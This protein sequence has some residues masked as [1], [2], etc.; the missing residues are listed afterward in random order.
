V[1]QEIIGSMSLTPDPSDFINRDVV[2][3]RVYLDDVKVLADNLAKFGP[4]RI[5][6]SHLDSNVDSLVPDPLTLVGRNDISTIDVAIRFDDQF[7]L[8]GYAE[9]ISV[10]ISAFFGIQAVVDKGKPDLLRTFDHFAGQL[11]PMGRSP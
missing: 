1:K 3:R 7:R 8:V 2:G 5:K 4:V 9:P 6:V 10:R 11:A